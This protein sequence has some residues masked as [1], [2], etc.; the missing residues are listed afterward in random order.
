LQPNSA[1]HKSKGTM[2]GLRISGSERKWG[3]EEP[4]KVAN[5]L[6]I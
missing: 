5:E 2:V 1:A 4:E 3:F 6:V